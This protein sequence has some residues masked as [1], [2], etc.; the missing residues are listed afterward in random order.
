MSFNFITGAKKVT[1]GLAVAGSL[2]LGWVMSDQGRAIL[3][4]VVHA[5]PKAS[6]VTVA[7]GFLATL[8]HK[9]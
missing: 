3:S 2:A 8:Y 5:Y 6:F 1:H 4:T 7:L 9:S